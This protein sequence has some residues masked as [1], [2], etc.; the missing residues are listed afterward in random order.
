MAIV[1][2]A[3]PPPGYLCSLIISMPSLAQRHTFGLSNPLRFWSA[4][5]ECKLLSGPGMPTVC[6]GAHP[7]QV[8][9]PTVTNLCIS[10]VTCACSPMHTG[11]LRLSGHPER[12]GK[13]NGGQARDSTR[14]AFPVISEGRTSCLSSDSFDAPGKAPTECHLAKTNANAFRCHRKSRSCVAA[15]AVGVSACRERLRSVAMKL[16]R[17]LR[18]GSGSLQHLT[19][20]CRCTL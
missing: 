11:I 13:M 19:M 1:F 17:P 20:Q 18:L 2:F 3:A 9:L 6:P 8:A 15:V 12:P 4:L 5:F 16:I 10:V 14:V 7:L